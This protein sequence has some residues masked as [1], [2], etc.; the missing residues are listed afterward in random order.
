MYTFEPEQ[1]QA[2]VR[3]GR[4]GLDPSTSARLIS[5]YGALE[6]WLRYPS[7]AVVGYGVTGFG[8][9][10]AQYARVL[11]E[12]GALGLAAFAWLVWTVV[13]S[14]ASA[15]RS[16][17]QPEDRGL[18]LGFLAGTIGLLA[19]AIGSNTFIIVRIMEPF[20]FF[21]GIVLMLPQLE[22]AEP[23]PPAAVPEVAPRRLDPRVA[24]RLGR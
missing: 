3:V 9:M 18:A 1:G 23:A 16:L 7:T 11:V 12:T 17:R 10:D 22:R 19:H 8:F 24:L 21:A 13:R 20:W 5:F 2:T 14:S 15:Y 4:V 6:G